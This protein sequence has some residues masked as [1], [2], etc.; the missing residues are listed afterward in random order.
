MT[1]QKDIFVEENS[2]GKFG[3]V[4]SKGEI[5]VP[6]VN[7]YID[8][9]LQGGGFIVYEKIVRGLDYSTGIIRF[10][11]KNFKDVFNRTFT[12]IKKTGENLLICYQ[13]NLCGVFNKSGETIA[14]ICFSEIISLDE[15]LFWFDA[16]YSL[17]QSLKSIL[18]SKTISSDQTPANV[19]IAER[20]GYNL[21]QGVFNID[22][23]LICNAQCRIVDILT[24]NGEKSLFA[25]QNQE[26]FI[27]TE[28]ALY[29]AIMNGKGEIISDY[30]YSEI[31]NI[32][33]QLIGEIE[34]ETGLKKIPL[35]NQGKPKK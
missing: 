11:D 28:G 34:T 2:Q 3:I 5:L 23:N 31:I 4:N 14:P 17:R 35:D 9:D 8:K 16:D 29:F 15:K 32:D 10:Y 27:E 20:D 18:S 21:F 30:I 24:H 22:G 26:K 7:D 6:I 13:G 19:N 33:G 25:I 1:S 12:R